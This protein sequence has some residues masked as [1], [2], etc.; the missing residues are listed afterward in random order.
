MLDSATW[1]EAQA[2][3]VQKQGEEACGGKQVKQLGESI[4]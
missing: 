3:M 2:K 1:V 4:A